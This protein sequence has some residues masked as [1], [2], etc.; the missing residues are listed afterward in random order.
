MAEKILRQDITAEQLRSQLKYDPETGVFVRL[1]AIGSSV[2]VGD[3]AGATTYFGYRAISVFGRLYKSHRLAW[4]YVYGQW[5]IGRLDHWD[6]DRMNNAIANLREATKTQ[7]AQNLKTAHRDNKS[8][9]IGVTWD[10]SRELWQSRIRADGKQMH[11]GRFAT[12]EDA[13]QAYLAAKH[14]LHPFGT[15]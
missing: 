12:P 3:I 5:P 11:L 8:G 10:Q 4:L 15:I 7:N 13:H 1:V 6:G 2:K 14:R 9:L